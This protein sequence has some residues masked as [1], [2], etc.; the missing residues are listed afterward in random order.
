MK[1][2]FPYF[3]GKSRVADLVWS[4]FG[5]VPNYVEPF[6]GS[7]AVLL[8]RPHH[9]ADRVETVNDA[10]GMVSNFWRAM[11]HDAEGVAKHADWPVNEVD[12]HA[13]NGWLIGRRESLTERL[14]DDPRWYDVE[15]AGWWVWG[16]CAFIGYTWAE[17][18]SRQLPHLGGP[19]MGVHRK[20]WRASMRERMVELG[21]RMRHV[22]V[23]CGDWSRVCSRS[24][25]YRMGQS[26]ASPNIT[27][28]V[29]LDPPYGDDNYDQEYAVG[30]EGV[31]DEVRAWC[32]EHGDNPDLRIA[33]C[34]YEGE[35]DELEEFGWEVVAWKNHGGY[36]VQ[37][38]GQGRANRT[39]E[40]IWFSP[41]CLGEPQRSLL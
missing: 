17:S 11:A 18:E 29:F 26:S 3:G 41:G 27:T 38:S 21:E 40:R 9:W 1:A 8:A 14:R 5:D 10:D 32:I 6:F 35:H 22:R 23:T 19:G 16:V 2:P 12:L 37:G 24:V 28:G 30:N 25:T 39:R 34:G 7:G 20:S 13:R 33:L 4:R 31:A 36:G 15:A